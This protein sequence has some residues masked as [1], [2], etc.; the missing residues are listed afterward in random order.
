MASMNKLKK[1]FKDKEILTNTEIYDIIRSY[2]LEQVDLA[3]RKQRSEDNFSLPAW[4]EFQAHQLG[5]IK[6]LEKI[7]DYVPDPNQRKD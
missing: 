5:I 3:S 2:I 4:S 1:S 6:G 7:L